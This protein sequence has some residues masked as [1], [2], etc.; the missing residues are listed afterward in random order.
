MFADLK[1]YDAS[2]NE[3]RTTIKETISSNQITLMSSSQEIPEQIFI[4][5]QK[6]NNFHYLQKERIFT[7]GISALQEVDRQLQAEKARVSALEARISAL[8]NPST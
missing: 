8:E 4:Y 3:I 2:N 6:V 7:V 5:G 1:L